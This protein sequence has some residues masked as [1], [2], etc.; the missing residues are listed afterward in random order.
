MATNEIIMPEG[1][2]LDE[3]K[4]PEGFIL[5]SVATDMSGRPMV[6]EV[7]QQRGFF[8]NIA[9]SARRQ[10]KGID[11]NIAYYDAAI[12]GLGDPERVYSA[13]QK[14]REEATL[15]P[16][17]GNFISEL[18]YGAAKVIPPWLVSAYE[19]AP[20]AAIGMGAGAAAGAL[21]GTAGYT[22][23][24][25]GLLTQTGGAAGGAVAGLGIGFKMGMANFWYKQGVGE[26]L[27]SM[28]EKGYDRDTS[29]IVAQIAGV[30]YALIELLQ[31]KQVTPALRQNLLKQLQKNTLKILGKAAKRYGTTIG[32]ETLEEIAQ[33]IVQIGAEDI[34]KTLSKKGIDIDYSYFKER[35]NRIMLT[36]TEALKSFSL[37]PLPGAALE[38]A[39]Q[40]RIAG[41]PPSVPAELRKPVEPT[42]VIPEGRVATRMPEHQLTPQGRVIIESDIGQIQIPEKMLT[43]EY[44]EDLERIFW[45]GNFQSDVPQPGLQRSLSVGDTINYRRHT[46]MVM[47]QGWRDI[48]GLS[49]DAIEAIQTA[50]NAIGLDA[51]WRQAEQR[52]KAKPVEIMQAEV[53][54]L[55][56]FDT[57]EAQRTRNRA[58]GLAD[59]LQKPVFVYQDKAGK[60]QIARKQPKKLA[61]TIYPLSAENMAD[62]DTLDKFARVVNQVAEIRKKQA[63]MWRKERGIRSGQAIEILKSGKERNLIA[64][65]MSALKGELPKIGIQPIDQY[66]TPEEIEDTLWEIRTS[67][68][69][70]PFEVITLNKAIEDLLVEG[71]LLQ[72]N[73]IKLLTKQFGD[74]SNKFVKAL[75]RAK[76]IKTRPGLMDI[77][78][79]PRTLRASFDTSY[80][81]RQGIF[82]AIRHPKIWGK[83]LGRSH[84]L[85]FGK[86]SKEEAQLMRAQLES[87][88]WFDTA[89]RAELQL[90][91]ETDVSTEYAERAEEFMGAEL[92]RKIPGAGRVI[93]RSERAYVEPGNL[94]RLDLF[95]HYAEKWEEGGYQASEKD[96]EDLAFLINAGTGRGRIKSYG[97]LA[98][99]TNAVFFAPRFV[100]S[101]LQ[102]I[103]MMADPRTSWAVRKIFWANT[104]SF[105]AGGIG[106]L[107]LLSLI[108]GVSVEDDPRSADFGKIRY[109]K[110]RI[111]FWAGYTPVVRLI[112][113]LISGQ[114]K[115]TDTGTM[116]DIDAKETL[117]RFVR[118]K[119]G[120]F[121]GLITDYF[122]GQTF[123]GEEFYEK[124]IDIMKRAK[125]LTLPFALDDIA[126]AIYHQGLEGGLIAAPVAFHGIG[127]Q[128]Y[129]LTPG[130]EVQLLKNRYAREIFGQDWEDL[131]PTVQKMLREERPQIEVAERKAAFER[132][133]YSFLTRQK[134]EQA[135]IGRKIQDS[136][137][138]NIQNELNSLYIEVG[139][140]SRRIATN[141]FLNDQRYK[142]YQNLTKKALNLILPQFINNP[143]WKTLPAEMRTEFLTELIQ[144]CKKYA[145]EEIIEKAERKDL[146][147]FYEITK[148]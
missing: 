136:L 76:G 63:P 7:E 79:L 2:I 130:K 30:P 90:V 37:V 44:G 48:T 131:G 141:W 115:A 133:N 22:T 36:G 84:K 94:H 59:E 118:S 53:R 49:D 142:E 113:Q 138:K 68:K 60:F 82:F 4:L 29:E 135:N 87:S 137:P 69:L 127:V 65:A 86:A 124:P 70:R 93:A 143:D 96:Y 126:E 104:V 129:P 78:N 45:Y 3:I 148:R 83:V 117:L 100:A 77:L 85:F 75:R 19:A 139:G 41:K 72:P 18:V 89:K 26:M 57:P 56:P 13:W 114:R 128:T 125:E 92:A 99:L 33:E 140:L 14:R 47:P 134:E 52:L 28:R 61:E 146:L 12:L 5:D 71:R 51:S 112:A 10:L 81:G 105:V 103:Q 64:P 102:L 1:F 120:P 101:R 108:P 121:P 15:D 74:R 31:I 24:P 132:T 8:A 80:A 107:G 34:T 40:T 91:S 88:K 73:E 67:R 110:Q 95:S 32:K 20:E 42:P 35:A 119:L 9:E 111:D 25:G 144:G 122:T 43:G 17:E 106:V 27:L 147:T 46:L 38:V 98:A 97:K 55:L 145:R 16:V 50:E 39:V 62:I 54:P 11:L 6:P 23:G 66:F 109:D 116:Y 123:I 21:V 58:E